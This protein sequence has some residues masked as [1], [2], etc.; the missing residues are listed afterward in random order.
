MWWR[1]VLVVPPRA[2]SILARTAFTAC[3]GIGDYFH[4]SG[5]RIGI[6]FT[7]LEIKRNIGRVRKVARSPVD[8]DLTV[9]TIQGVNRGC[10]CAAELYAIL[11][12]ESC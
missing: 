8:S 6:V 4:G 11:A 7:I 12:G 1:I 2:I 10:Y 5:F 9:S 3:P